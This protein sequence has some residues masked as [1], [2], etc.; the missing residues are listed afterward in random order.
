L[1]ARMSLACA[2][3]SDEA[4]WQVQHQAQSGSILAIKKAGNDDDDLV[5]NRFDLPLVSVKSIKMVVRAKHFNK[6]PQATRWYTPSMILT[7]VWLQQALIANLEIGPESPTSKLPN[8][9]NK[10]AARRK[11]ANN[12]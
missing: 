2:L 9:C 1:S 8:T 4:I 7:I 12:Q 5:F 10:A 11:G 6:V 3:K